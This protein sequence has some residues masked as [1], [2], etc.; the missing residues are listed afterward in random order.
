MKKWMIVSSVVALFASGCIGP[1]APPAPGETATVD[2]SIAVSQEIGNTIIA[3]AVIE[4]EQWSELRFSGSGTVVEVL[5]N[6]GDKVAAGDVL[7]RLDPANAALAVQEAESALAEAQAQRAQALAGPRPEEIAEAEAQLEAVQAA[8][9]QAAAQRDQ[10][11]GGAIDAD[12][13]AA[14]A[15][16]AAAQAE[17]LVARDAYDAVRDRTDDERDNEDANYALYAANEAL[18]AAQTIVEAQQSLASARLYDA[19]MAVEYASAQVDASL[20]ELELLKAGPTPE[21]IAISNALVLQAEAALAAAQTALARTELRAPFAGTATDL[22]TDVGELVSPGQIV[23]VLAIVDR[24]QVRTVDLTE[25]DVA[26]I[27]EGQPVDVTVDALPELALAGSVRDIA[28]EA[29][30]YRGDIVYAVTVELDDG[31]ETALR[32]GMTALVEIEAR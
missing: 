5:V 31:S 1:F 25:L 28:L 10:L 18:D 7:I 14:E 12:I 32:W 16:L 2:P 13:A 11:A 22:H 9:S 17:Q 3:E 19:A 29:T 4:P 24:L 20:A 27:A 26:R 21:D 8:L 6:E 23:V 30:D 15:E